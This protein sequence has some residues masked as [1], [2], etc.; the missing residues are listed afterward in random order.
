[1]NASTQA[2]FS[3][4]GFL[5]VAATAAAIPLLA[6]CSPGGSGSAAGGSGNGTLK[7]WDMP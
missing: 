6:A 5:G 1:M 2:K 3:R 4:R 7:F